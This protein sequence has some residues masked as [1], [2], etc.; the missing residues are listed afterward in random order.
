MPGRSSTGTWP[1]SETTV[2]SMPTRAGPASNTG[3]ASPSEARTWAASVGETAVNRFALGAA[4]GTPAASSRASA[5][6]WEGTR[7]PTVGN[8]AVT[9][10]GMEGCLGTTIV[11]G[12]GQNARASFSAFS[13]H[14]AASARA[15]AAS[16]TCTM[17]GLDAGRPLVS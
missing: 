1:A 5:T 17:S 16:F 11:R 6:G 12:P 14:T 2:D 4:S 10:P 9:M 13:G 15:A 7:N 8:P 3:T